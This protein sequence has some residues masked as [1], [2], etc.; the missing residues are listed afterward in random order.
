MEKNY[1]GLVVAALAKNIASGSGKTTLTA[2]LLVAGE[3]KNPHAYKIGPDY[4]D[5]KIHSRITGRACFN[6]D[7]YAMPQEKIIE[8]LNHTPIGAPRIIEGVMGLYDGARG[9]SRYGAGSS[10][11]VLKKFRFALLLVVRGDEDPNYIKQAIKKIIPQYHLLAV[12]VNDIT[13]RLIKKTWKNIWQ[14]N[15]PPLVFL[16]QQNF[17][18]P[19]RHLGLYQGE[20]WSNHAWRDLKK[21]FHIMA[22]NFKHIAGDDVWQKLWVASLVNKKILLN[23]KTIAKPSI[24][25]STKKT[26]HLAVAYDTAFGFIYPHHILSW[27]KKN[28]AVEFFSPLADQTPPEKADAIFLPGG[29]PELHLE[30]LIQAKKFFFAIHKAAQAGKIIYGECGGFM[31]LGQYIIDKN[32]TSFP[33]L[34]LLPHGSDFSNNILHLG[35]RHILPYKKNLTTAQKK[36]LTKIF[37]KNIKQPLYGHEFHYCREIAGDKH[38][39][40]AVKDSL[41]KKLGDYGQ[42]KKNIMGSFLHLI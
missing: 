32:G 25:P 19:H 2:A 12:V 9:K 5:G 41:Q 42:V 3:E 16:P 10:N 38:P 17:T 37:D 21:K 11:D 24:T 34:R 8:L 23:K 27:Q 4:L 36:F 1:G 35:Y 13:G 40:F 18:L 6:L 28:I 30:K 31:M 22:K 20:E 7:S 14:K 15:Y 33:T 29:Y 39:L 26:Y